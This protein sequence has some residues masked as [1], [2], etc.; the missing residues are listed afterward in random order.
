MG[1]P[2]ADKISAG[3]SLEFRLLLPVFNISKENIMSHITTNQNNE[4]F[5]QFDF[6]YAIEE[7]GEY[8]CFDNEQ[9]KQKYLDELKNLLAQDEYLWAKIQETIN[10]TAYD[11][12]TRLN[13]QEKE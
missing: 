12:A 1:L 8:Y 4:H 13:L 10:Q 9:Q 6:S 3:W 2:R 7:Q 5:S 11:V